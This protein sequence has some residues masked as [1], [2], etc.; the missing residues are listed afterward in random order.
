MVYCMEFME[1]KEAHFTGAT[2]VQSKVK[3]AHFYIMFTICAKWETWEC[4][5]FKVTKVKLINVENNQ[6]KK[7]FRCKN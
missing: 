2:W 5:M 1:G 4:F 6:T 3:I 7:C